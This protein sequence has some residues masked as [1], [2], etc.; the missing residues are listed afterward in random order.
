[1]L[2]SVPALMA[3]RPSLAGG[4]ASSSLLALCA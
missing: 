2:I 3:L 4:L 1:M